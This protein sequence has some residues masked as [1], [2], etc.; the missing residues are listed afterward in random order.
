MQLLG[1]LDGWRSCR[2][3]RAS[4]KPSNGGFALDMRVSKVS[5]RG[6]VA[7]YVPLIRCTIVAELNDK[8]LF[9]RAFRVAVK[10]TCA[11]LNG[12]GTTC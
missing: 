3:Y 10:P 12:P 2:L 11:V 1:T 4:L 6:S 7:E 5:N 8:G 9:H